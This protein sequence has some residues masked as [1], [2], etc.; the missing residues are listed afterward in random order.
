MITANAASEPTPT[1]VSLLR[2]R[3][4]RLAALVM[5]LF[6]G[7]IALVWW[8]HF[9]PYVTTEDARVAAR[10]VNVAPSG[11]GG[12][13]TTV[14]IREGDHVRAGDVLLTLDDRPA[15]A[16]LAR[17][18]AAVDIAAARVHTAEAELALE[19]RL[20]EIAVQR[21]AAG[22]SSARAGV[23]LVVHGPRAEE[24]ERARATAAAA[25]ARTDELAAARTRAEALFASGT[26]SKVEVERAL[27]LEEQARNTARASH[28]TLALLKRGTR[29]EEVAIARSALQQA[30]AVLAEAGA[31]SERVALRE[32]Q[33]AAGR[34]A[35]VQARAELA[36]AELAVAQTRLQSS[37]DGVVI[38]V[39]MDPGDYVAMG[40]AAV[41]VADL[42]HAW[43]A[44]NVEETAVGMLRPGEPVE[45]EVD[46]GGGTVAGHVEVVAQTVASQF[47]LIP[48]DNAAGN[49]TK[50]VQRIPIRVAIDEMGDRALRVG[51]S[52]MLRIRVR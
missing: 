23:S 37:I 45:I 1:R 4:V 2:H 5:A 31:G 6:A 34:A 47:A 17:A 33:L 24:I 30:E 38:R 51:Q 21:A 43:I 15:R 52:V 39:T 26:I 9:R 22:L 14:R 44:A 25:D 19:R 49:F 11:P 41:V 3:R 7:A 40:Q 32:Q 16:E 27:S 8:Q 28:A 42:E 35:E 46:E 48:A 13:V 20:A 12:S 18:Q 50:V 36:I 10:V 29:G